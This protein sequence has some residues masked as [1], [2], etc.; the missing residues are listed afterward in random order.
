MN[1]V[2]ERVKKLPSYGP[3]LNEMWNKERESFSTKIIVLDDDPTGVQTV[4]GVPVFTDWDMDTIEEVFKED[5]QLV[6]ILT[7]SRAF[8]VSETT[9][10]HKDIAQRIAQVSERLGQPFLLVSRG[11]STLRGHYPLET[12]TLKETIEEQSTL[13]YDGEIILPF[14][15]EGGRETIDDVHYVKQGEAYIPAGETEFAK[16]RMF[17]FSSS[18][19]RDWIEEKTDGEFKRESVHSISLDELRALNVDAITEKL[20]KLKNF[21]KLIVNAVTEDDVKVFSI[22]LLRAIKL[23]KNYLFRTAASFTKVIGDIASKPYLE[24]NDL[25]RENSPYG[26]LVVIGSHVQKSTEQLNRLK[27]KKSL[28]FIEFSC[29]LVIDES[30]F[31]EEIKRVQHE[32]NEKV[33]KGTTTV[34]YTS[35]ERLDLGEGRGEEELALSVRISSAVTQ[36]VN[37]CHPQ[38]RFVIA[39]GGITSSDVGTLGLKVKKAEVLGQIAP[40]VPVWKTGKESVFPAIPYVIFPGNVGEVDTLKEVVEK[41]Q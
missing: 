32:I 9:Q 4:H 26:G 16:D 29:N 24:A 21:E 28:H 23:G 30:L 34:V 18:N 1:N 36:F 8:S 38:P 11:D 14:F 15:K 20:M 35:R 33:S 13:C 40:G 19:L 31:N 39:K 37:R 25:L 2:V 6:F 22:A 7:N 41:L 5:R 10:V 27:E 12:V 17:G 3:E